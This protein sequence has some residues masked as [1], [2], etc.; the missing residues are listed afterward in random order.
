MFWSHLDGSWFRTWDRSDQRTVCRCYNSFK[1]KQFLQ[2]LLIIHLHKQ[3][4]QTSGRLGQKLV[5]I[6]SVIWE[7]VTGIMIQLLVQS[8]CTSFIIIVCLWASV[9]ITW[10]AN[11]STWFTLCKSWK[12]FS[13][14]TGLALL[15]KRRRPNLGPLPYIWHWIFILKLSSIFCSQ[16]KIL[17]SWTSKGDR[18][19]PWCKRMSSGMFLRTIAGILCAL[20]LRRPRTD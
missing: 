3:T 1:V 5:N 17:R 15:Q 9:V 2:N 16:V 10:E 12:F 18:V 8:E 7:Q 13:P 14:F 11:L 20:D 4:E 19:V 6:Q